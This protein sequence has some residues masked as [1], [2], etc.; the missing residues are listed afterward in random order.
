[1]RQSGDWTLLAYKGLGGSPMWVVIGLLVLGLAW[2]V[3][4]ASRRHK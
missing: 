4:A 3:V 1:M 2:A